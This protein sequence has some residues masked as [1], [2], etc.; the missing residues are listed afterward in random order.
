M[1][2]RMKSKWIQ[3]GLKRPGALTKKAKAS[4]QSPMAFAHKHYHD[5]G[6]T[7]QQA[8]YAVNAN[9]GR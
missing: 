8:R 9:K 6:L 2:S 5:S 7:G 3:K 1:P 4:G